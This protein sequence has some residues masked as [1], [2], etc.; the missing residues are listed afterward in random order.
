MIAPAKDTNVIHLW[1]ENNITKS[2]TITT[3]AD[4]LRALNDLGARASDLLQANSVIWVEGPSDRTYLNRWLELLHSGKYR[5][6]IDYTV[7]FYGGRLLSHLSMERDRVAETKEDEG[8]ELIQLLKINQHSAILIASDRGKAADMIN[9]T[10]ERIKTESAA[11]GVFC[12]IT[13]GREI[14]NC[15]PVP[16]IE[17]AFG[18][19]AEKTVSIKLKPYQ[20]IED[21][22]AS[23]LKSVWKRAQYYE[24]AKA[25]RAHEISVH[26]TAEQLS[27][28]IRDLIAGIVNVIEHKLR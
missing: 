15:L 17:A 28:D 21:A 2:R 25:Q 27:Q 23:S 7:M 19:L 14:E 6:G 8:A 22:L 3:S 10:K 9:P 5:E 18:A 26:M 11:S 1:L 24:H 13:P 20:D 16:A 12:W 4:S